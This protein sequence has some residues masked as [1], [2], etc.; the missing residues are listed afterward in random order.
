MGR[1]SSLPSADLS[2]PRGGNRLSSLLLRKSRHG[3]ERGA[4][5]HQP[6][7]ARLSVSSA[8]PTAPALAEVNRSVRAARAL[9]ARKEPAQPFPAER[10]Q[11]MVRGT[12]PPV[13][14]RQRSGSRC[15]LGSRA[16]CP[17]W[18][19]ESPPNNCSTP[20][21]EPH[22]PH[23]EV[24]RDP[25]AAD[26]SPGFGGRLRAGDGPGSAPCGCR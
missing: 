18:V 26:W 13:S 6:G 1:S 8:W 2:R 23:P 10:A 5:P 19:Q 9:P 22:S 7:P 20:A 15:P 16:G 17:D 4:E 25:E 11:R 21:T 24:A 14:A 3:R 12:Q